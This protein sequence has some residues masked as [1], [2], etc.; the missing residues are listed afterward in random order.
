MN[1]HTDICCIL[2]NRIENSAV[3]I[4]KSLLEKQNYKFDGIRY[5][6]DRT[7][8]SCFIT[9]DME[10]KKELVEWYYNEAEE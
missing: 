5:Q 6:F 3:P 4:M 7:E 2:V 9:D 1:E 10:S 8:Q